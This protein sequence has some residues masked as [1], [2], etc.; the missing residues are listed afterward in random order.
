MLFGWFLL[1]IVGIEIFKLPILYGVL[2]TRRRR[3]EE[4]GRLFESRGY[5]TFGRKDTPTVNFYG[6]FTSPSS[7]AMSLV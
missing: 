7:S 3:N 5:G 1:L 4:D 6:K 2:S